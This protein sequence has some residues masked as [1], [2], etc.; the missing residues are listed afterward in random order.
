MDV[1]KVVVF[2]LQVFEWLE[3]VNA[4]AKGGMVSTD[5]VRLL[6]RAPGG[7]P[8]PPSS[9]S[10]WRLAFQLSD[11]NVLHL[12]SKPVFLIRIV[13]FVFFCTLFH[14]HLDGVFGSLGGLHGLS[15]TTF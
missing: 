4:H 6:A 5:T 15:L 10:C 11:S 7:V 1:Q 14:V 8:A 3:I 9:M 12:R 2:R 13:E